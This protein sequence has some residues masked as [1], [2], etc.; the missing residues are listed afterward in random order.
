MANS[1][2]LQES[3][4]EDDPEIMQLIRKEKDRQR[5]GLELIASEV[6][7]ESCDMNCGCFAIHAIPLCIIVPGDMKLLGTHF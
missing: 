5:R 7:R 4:E 2:T 3:L 1:W 6:S